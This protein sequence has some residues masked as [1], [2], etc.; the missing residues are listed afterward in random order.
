MS[1]LQT[2]EVVRMGEKQLDG[3]RAQ[4]NRIHKGMK[5]LTRRKIEEL[6]ALMQAHKEVAEEIAHLVNN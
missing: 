4:M 1:V 5:I 2:M 6:N 3:I